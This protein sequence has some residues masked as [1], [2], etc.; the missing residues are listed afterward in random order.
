MQPS[1]AS[2]PRSRGLAFR[3]GVDA[4]CLRRSRRIEG[5]RYQIVTP[6]RSIENRLPRRAWNIESGCVSK[7]SSHRM[8]WWITITPRGTPL[9]R[10]VPYVNRAIQTRSGS[11]IALLAL[12]RQR[13][14]ETAHKAHSRCRRIE[15]Y[16]SWK[17]G[18]RSWASPA[19]SLALRRRSPAYCGA[20]RGL[21]DCPL[22]AP[23]PA[24]KS[25]PLPGEGWQAPPSLSRRTTHIGESGEC[26]GLPLLTAPIMHPEWPCLT[27]CPPSNAPGSMPLRT[28]LPAPVLF[29]WRPDREAPPTQNRLTQL[30]HRRVHSGLQRTLKTWREA[31]HFSESQGFGSTRRGALKRAVFRGKPSRSTCKR[32]GQRVLR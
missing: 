17:R 25:T 8:R 32:P 29:A 31:P 1:S 20:R 28:P 7:H 27:Q 15:D 22:R 21:H 11:S 13:G 10:P 23:Y 2:R 4:P 26:I 14:I 30:R 12:R 9:P 18:H 5:A 3:L 19:T 6:N 16:L 24:L